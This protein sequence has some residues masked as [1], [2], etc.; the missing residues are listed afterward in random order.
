MGAVS[1]TGD[2]SDLAARGW[3]SLS[4]SGWCIAFGADK[5]PKLDG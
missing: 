4:F 2:S 5:I 1:G 3:P